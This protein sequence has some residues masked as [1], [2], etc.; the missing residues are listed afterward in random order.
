MSTLIVDVV[1]VEEVKKH[2]GADRLEL[3]RVK[4]WWVISGTGNWTVGQKGVYLPPDSV[5]S[6]ALTDKWGITK[7]TAPLAKQCDGT[8][9]AGQRIRA[10]RLR[11]ERSFGFLAPLEDQTIPVGTNMVDVLGV[12]K[13]EPP[14]KAMDGDAASPIATFHAYTDIE[15]IGNFPGVLEDGEEVVFTEKLHGTNSRVG[16]IQMPDE[17]TGVMTFSYVAGSHGTRR[18]PQNEQGV[19]SLYWL[20][21]TDNMKNLLVELCAHANNVIVYGEIYGPGIQDMAY[22]VKSAAYRAFD[23]A[24]NGKYLDFDTKVALFQKH[25][26]DMV[27]ILYRGPFSMAV[28]A[29]HTDGTTTVCAADQN[30]SKFKGREGVVVTPVKERYSKML[31][32][33]GRVI[34]KSISVDYHERKGGTEFH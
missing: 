28:L 18:K 12:T 22:G 21:Q 11:G 7:Y 30:N 15:N 20:P 27:P 2:P 13:Y 24:V 29:Q 32:N 19:K 10:T 31:P 33:F 4:N 17:E 14:L 6:E 1:E 26:I 5:V 23:I 8:R 3:V 25:G 9:P 34:L 16:I